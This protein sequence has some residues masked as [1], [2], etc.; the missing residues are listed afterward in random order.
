MDVNFFYFSV[1]GRFIQRQPCACMCVCVCKL[2]SLKSSQKLLTG[3]LPNFT[4]MFPRY[5]LKT[6]L[7]CYRKIR[8]V[9]QYRCSSASSLFKFILS[10]ANAFNLDQSEISLFHTE[11]NTI[12]P[13]LYHSFH[14]LILTIAVIFLVALVRGSVIFRES[15]G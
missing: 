6:S 9:E 15:K 7:H 11:L 5:R 8:P 13:F 4:G 10:S 1:F 12:S 3:F 14:T 2:F